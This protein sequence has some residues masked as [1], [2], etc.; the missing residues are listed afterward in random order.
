VKDLAELAD[1]PNT[2]REVARV[3]VFVLFPPPIHVPYR[4]TSDS[5]PVSR[6]LENFTGQNLKNELYLRTW[7]HCRPHA[8]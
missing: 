5:L 7:N 6:L 2:V 8:V 1:G 4:L 3:G